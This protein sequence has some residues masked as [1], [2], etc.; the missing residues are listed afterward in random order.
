MNK[1]Q[2][3]FTHLIVV[4]LILIVAGVIGFTALRVV[5]SDKSK[6]KLTNNS[7]DKAQIANNTKPSGAV[8]EQG[9]SGC[10]PD[11]P[12]AEAADAFTAL[13]F[14]PDEI[15][16][17][18]VGKETNDS[19]FVY[20]WVKT[21][22][23]AIFAPATGKLYL[24]RH[25]VFVVDGKNGNDYDMFFAVDC[26]TVY[27]FNHITNPR[28]DI[29]ATYPAAD[30]PSGDYANGGQDIAERVKPK[31]AITVKAGESLGYTTGT[32]TA[33]DFDFAVGIASSRESDKLAVCPFT[34][35]KDPLKS[36]LMALLGP[37]STYTPQAGYACD[38]ESKKF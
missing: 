30:L 38:I 32:P 8:M 5:S 2:N 34:Q 1:N 24:I 7:S 15:K 36:Q 31:T 11:A 9:Q 18:T 25:K 20:P 3:G 17:V 12:V 14:K 35:F 23:T 21:D 19:R 16:V 13:P 37:K 26:K 22:K 10:V 33:H 6:P 28:D 29:K 27:R 4:I